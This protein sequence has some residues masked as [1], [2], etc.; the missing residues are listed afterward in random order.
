MS[1]ELTKTQHF[2]VRPDVTGTLGVG[3]R[4][5]G[6]K[7]RHESKKKQ[8]KTRQK[9]ITRIL[10]PRPIAPRPLSTQTRDRAQFWRGLAQEGRVAPENELILKR[11][12]ISDKLLVSSTIAFLALIS[13]HNFLGTGRCTRN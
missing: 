9:T 4:G 6:K 7:N 5:V 12:T 2:R 1:A 13:I 8:E 10:T 11:A 3:M